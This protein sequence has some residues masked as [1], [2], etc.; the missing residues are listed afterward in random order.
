MSC[1]NL[2]CCGMWA[3][4]GLFGWMGGERTWRIEVL[5]PYAA[6]QLRLLVGSYIYGK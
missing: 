6:P 5:L 4:F 2:T 1:W 3:F